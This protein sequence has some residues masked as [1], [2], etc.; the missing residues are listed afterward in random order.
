M[1]MEGRKEFHRCIFYLSI[2]AVERRTL[3]M[4]L[5]NNGSKALER[6]VDVDASCHQQTVAGM[7]QTPNSRHAGG[8]NHSRVQEVW[9]DTQSTPK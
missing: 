8:F 1:D 3:K 2:S 7:V 6:V 4:C 9:E 5:A